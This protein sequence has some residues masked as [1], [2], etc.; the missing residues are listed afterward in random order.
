[1]LHFP[2][3]L[4]LHVSHS[5][6]Y[7]REDVEATPVYPIIHLIR[8]DVLHYIDTPLTYDALLA[9]DITYTLVQPLVEKYLAFQRNGN[10]SIVFCFL[11]NRVHFLHDDNILTATVSQS[12]AALCEILAIRT[13]RDYGNRDMYGNSMLALTRA[14]TTTWPVYNGADPNVLEQA[15]VERDGDLEERVGNAIEMAILSKSK[16]FIKSSSCQKVINAIWT[17]TEE[18]PST[19]MIPIEL[20][21][22]I[23]IARQLDVIGSFVILFILFII[24]IEVS[25]RDNLGTP[26]KL[27]MI[28]SLGFTLE[29]VA[30]MQEHGIKGEHIGLPPSRAQR[31]LRLY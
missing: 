15:R 31:R 16:R 2:S 20:L 1:M 12:R 4:G 6:P 26:E 14:L 22:L 11:I 10:Y 21:F 19:S 17:H 30:A 3:A 25:D 28:Y 8:R 24:A 23:T 29:K 27:F 18:G 7:Y 13:F 5:H 9:P